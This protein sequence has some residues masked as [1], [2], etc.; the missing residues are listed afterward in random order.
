MGIRNSLRSVADRI[1]RGDK[2]GERG[3]RPVEQPGRDVLY[4]IAEPGYPNYGDELIA[5]EWLKYLAQRHPESPVV[6]DCARPGPAAAILQGIHPRASFTDT[7]RRLGTEN[8]FPYDG[9]I[10]DIAG[11]VGEALEND[12]LS[13]R[14]AMGIRLL[15]HRTRS[16][17][18]LGG[19][20]MRGD[21]T[22][23][24]S[25]LA[26]GPFA[27]QHGIP[28]IATGLGLMPLDGESLAF[29]R[30]SAA[31]F[32]GFTVRDERTLETLNNGGSG[33]A[34]AELAP[35]DCF[36]NAL[37]G[38]YM[39]DESLPAV[40]LCVQSDFVADSERLHTYAV[41]ILETWGIGLHDPIGVV[42]C[43]PLIDRPIYDYLIAYGYDHVRFFPLAEILERGFPAR[44]GQRWVSTRYHPHILAAAKGCTGSFISVDAGYY[45]VKHA[46]VLR[47]GS[48]W[49]KAALGQPAPLPGEGFAD[50]N[51]PERYSKQI[52]RIADILY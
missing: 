43:N 22:C 34:I 18:I 4:L 37:K 7:L 39:E 28:V 11:F 16:I 29:A 5:A 31:A 20:Y 50:P 45:D 42:E 26:I 38:C 46:A 33:K 27:R 24:L 3:R 14:Y 9:P 17:H 13:P 6:M 25:R 10:K 23:N 51:L 48:H 21:W 8:P 19:G 2:P 1:V 32:D 40:M 15:Q 41:S 30:H 44:E 52:R 47:M 49:T 36:V 35:D 12:G